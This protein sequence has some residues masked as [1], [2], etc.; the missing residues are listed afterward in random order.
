MPNSKKNLRKITEKE[1]HAVN[2][3]QGNHSEHHEVLP[4]NR[5]DLWPW[6]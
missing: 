3:Q 5:H 6:I 4:T 1:T 2:A